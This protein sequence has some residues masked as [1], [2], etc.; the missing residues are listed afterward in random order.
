MGRMHSNGKGLSSSALP[1]KRTPPSWCKTT[2]TDVV[3]HITKLARKGM[4]PSSIGVLLR[5][6]HGVP[7]VGGPAGVCVGVGGAMRLPRMGARPC[8]RMRACCCCL[9]ACPAPAGAT[10]P[11]P[12]YALSRH[13]QVGTVTGSK[14][15][16]IL[17]A[18]GLAP[19]IPE[20]LYHLIKKISGGPPCLHVWGRGGARVGRGGGGGGAPRRRLPSGDG[21][22]HSPRPRSP[23]PP[24][25]V[26]V[27]KHLDRN[28]KDKDSKFRWGRRV[29]WGGTACGPH[30]CLHA[31]LG[32]SRWPV[33]V[34]ACAVKEVPRAPVWE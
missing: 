1:Y 28:R 24:H 6:Q 10:H 25:A 26:S 22:S 15:L 29:W 12:L 30:A 17:K 23:S 33:W 27:R 34:R 3:E 32:S 31:W 21:A 16:R 13:A 20:D 11:H 14:I 8:K 7:Q 4:T 19:E 5:D 9:P 2:P 18:H